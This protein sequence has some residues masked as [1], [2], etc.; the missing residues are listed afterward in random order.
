MTKTNSGPYGVAEPNSSGIKVIVVGLGFAG[1]ATMI[2]CYRKGHTVIGF[3]QSLHQ[4]PKGDIM[5]IAANGMTVMSHWQSGAVS[6]SIREIGNDTTAIDI[7][8]EAGHLKQHISLSNSSRVNRCFT[9][10]AEA[11]QIVCDYARS[12]GLDMRFGTRVDAYWESEA[13][14]GIIVG[15]EKI[16]ADCVVACDGVQS[17][18]RRIITGEDAVPLETGS[19]VF[20]S[21]FHA[22]EIADDP[23]ARWFLENAIEKNRINVYI[24]KDI[25]ALVAV[26]GDGRYVAWLITHKDDGGASTSWVQPVDIKDALRTIDK[27]PVK[28]KLA[29]VINRTPAG[30]CLN[31]QLLSAKPLSTWVS[32]RGRMIVLGDA[33]HPMLPST[34][35]GASQAIEDAAVFAI[36][37]ELGTK[38]NVPLSIRATEKIRYARATAIQAS[39]VDTQDSYFDN[40]LEGNSVEDTEHLLTGSLMNL[41]YDCQAQ[42]YREFAKAVQAIETGVKYTPTG[43]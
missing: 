2:E 29:A 23:K 40:G 30:K 20:R 34:G 37:L 22:Q 32:K 10:R 43:C 5:G 9:P 36:C 33:A 18:A 13:D 7:Y 6:N 39:S 25:Y 28:E 42:A 24:E 27:W 16:V 15:N 17:Q 21:Y 8:N 1:L 31:N 12:L 41:E 11:I 38:M 3:E 14:A 35:Q 19:A 26:L 4:S